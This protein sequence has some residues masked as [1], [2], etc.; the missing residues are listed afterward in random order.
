MASIGD[1][2]NFCFYIRRN[3][4]LPSAQRSDIE[5]ILSLLFNT[6]N[7]RKR[8]LADVFLELVDKEE[9]PEY[10]QVSCFSVMRYL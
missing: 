10:Y 3:M 5:A 6:T 1:L 8:R 4:G 9:Y 2:Q 7:Q